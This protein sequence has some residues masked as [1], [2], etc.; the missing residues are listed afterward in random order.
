MNANNKKINEKY[1]NL[2]EAVFDAIEA[3]Y[4]RL[5][6]NAHQKDPDSPF[7]NTGGEYVNDVFKVHAYNW[8]WDE[9]VADSDINFNYKNG[10]FCAT[11]YKHAHRG[12][13]FWSKKGKRINAEFLNIMLKDCLKSMR[14]DLDCG[15]PV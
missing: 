2:V 6:W 15:D 5:Y 1:R 4:E 3:E 9:L 11:W 14:E 8:N 7:R 12:L 13:Y 10:L